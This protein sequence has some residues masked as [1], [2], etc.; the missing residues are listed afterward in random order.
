MEWQAAG[1]RGQEGAG[2]G[3]KQNNCTVFLVQY[4]VR[5]P[6]LAELSAGQ[7]KAVRLGMRDLLAP[8]NGLDDDDV[9][10]LFRQGSLVVDARI[11]MPAGGDEPALPRQR[12]VERVIRD[13]VSVDPTL[14][15]PLVAREDTEEE[16]CHEDVPLVICQR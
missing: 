14:D 9:I 2:E 4:R 5:S 16:L 8:I 11:S 6:N 10:I 7:Q 13:T 12:A 3:E 1:S 15:E